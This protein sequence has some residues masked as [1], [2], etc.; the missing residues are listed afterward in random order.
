MKKKTVVM[1]FC[2]M[3]ALMGGYEVKSGSA[4]QGNTEAVIQ[5]QETESV[6]SADIAYN[7]EDYV[8]LGDYSN[9]EVDLNAAD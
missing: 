7:V 3:A 9:I 2:V 1:L 4:E 8:T 6:S 5:E